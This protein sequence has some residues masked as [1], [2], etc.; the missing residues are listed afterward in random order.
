MPKVHARSGHE[1]LEIA[2][3]QACLGKHEGERMV[4]DLRGLLE[5]SGVLAEDVEAILAAPA[6]LAIYRR[7]V[8]NGLSAVMLRM[9]PRTRA[10]LNAACDDR[11]DFDFAR[12]VDEVGPRTH[13]LRDV[14]GELFAWAEPRWRADPKVPAYLP[15]LATHEL[16]HFSIA[17]S[18][19]P[20]TVPSVGEVSLDR[21]LAF[22]GTT[23]LLRYGWAVHELPADESSRDEPVRR[24]VSLLGYRGAS[25][26]VRW[27]ELTS[28]AASIVERLLSGEPLGVAVERACA[29]RSVG[30][31]TV[32]EDIVKLLADLGARGVVL[33]ARVD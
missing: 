16:A 11:F 33:G 13:Y 10:R 31:P 23:R 25:S 21:P 2:I 18:A 5:G 7:L 12:F 29:Q 22:S 3:A 17:S 20:D 8:R 32:R 30:A 15:D 26:A 4:S 27:L 1:A 19:A 24:D 9:L 6:R 14:P 28:L